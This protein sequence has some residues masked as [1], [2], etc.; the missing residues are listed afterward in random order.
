MLVPPLNP[1]RASTERTVEEPLREER[2]AARILECEGS[3]VGQLG[4]AVNQRDKNVIVLGAHFV[5]S[6]VPPRSFS[7]FQ[8]MVV[9]Q[10]MGRIG[11]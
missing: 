11:P 3:R 5:P 2:A 7:H 1:G 4:D 8:R 10:D 9:R 6:W